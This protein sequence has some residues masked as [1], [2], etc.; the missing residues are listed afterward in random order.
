MSTNKSTWKKLTSMRLFM[1][2]VCLLAIIIVATITIPG[3]LSMSLKNGV[4]YGYPVDVIN[5]ASELV[6]LSVGMTLVTA[7]SGGQDISVGAVMAVAGAVCC[8]ILSGGEVSVNSLSAPIIVAFLA[9]LV[10]SGIC[11]AFNGLL[12]SYLNVQPMV[13]TLI[14]FSAARAIGLL[15]CNNMIVYVREDSFKIF[16]G[17]L[18]F[19]P[20][21]IVVAAVCIII[22]SLILKKTALGLYVQSV[23]INK[24]ASRI[25]GIKSERII[26]LCYIVCGLC[27]GIAGIV[28]SSRISSADSNNIGL[29]FELDAILAVALGGNSLG[30]GKFRLTG[31][32]IGA[33][34]IQAITTTL[35]ALGVST[36]QA[37]VYKAVIVIIIVA[38]Q[39]PPFKDYMKKMSAKR[40][41]AKG[42][43]A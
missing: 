29:N 21:P 41:L 7:A 2:L 30:G 6:I 31:S 15:L 22:T 19:I 20:T 43:V 14:L 13:A 40:Q 42:G 36:E 38:I 34:T 4:P 12:V 3:F 1:P 10:A 32:I 26:F 35:Y 27:A 39:A 11:G 16:G 33:Y 25:A 5:R 28:A 24:K 17:Y 9:A 8:Q 23:G 37:P 18:G